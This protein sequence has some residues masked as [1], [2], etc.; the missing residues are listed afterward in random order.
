M[1]E[2][3]RLPPS[4]LRRIPF[5]AGGV[6]EQF[7]RQLDLGQV[8]TGGVDPLAD[9]LLEKADYFEAIEAMG[10]SRDEGAFRRYKY[11]RHHRLYRP[12]K[13]DAGNP[14]T[15][16][17]RLPTRLTPDENFELVKSV[18]R[19]MDS[20]TRGE[21]K[22]RPDGQLE[23][24]LAP[25][26]DV[27]GPMIAP[28]RPGPGRSRPARPDDVFGTPDTPDIHIPLRQQS[29]FETP[30]RRIN[31]NS[32]QPESVRESVSVLRNASI[33]HAPSSGHTYSMSIRPG[34]TKTQRIELPG[35]TLDLVIT[36]AA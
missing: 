25:N 16:E 19:G 33:S 23:P 32:P 22:L 26:A 21:V 17:Q 15:A 2:P 4:V 29:S 9:N 13:D 14:I 36:M 10:L 30:E 7:N 31:L 18:T 1:S 5:D 24:V 20:V 34:E 27:G 8:D 6:R 3:T 28:A 12:D 11:L 35:L